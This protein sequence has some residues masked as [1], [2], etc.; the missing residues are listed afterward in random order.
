MLGTRE[1][2]ILLEAKQ[3]GEIELHVSYVVSDASWSPKYD[4]RVGSQTKQMQV[5]QYIQ[6][7]DCVYVSVH[8]SLSTHCLFCLSVCE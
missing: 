7:F 3:S 6:M 4:V 8:S 5:I 2:S 1:L